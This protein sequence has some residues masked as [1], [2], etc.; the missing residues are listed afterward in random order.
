MRFDKHASLWVY[1]RGLLQSVVP[2]GFAPRQSQFL[3]KRGG[4][5]LHDLFR[6]VAGQ[7]ARRFI[8]MGNDPNVIG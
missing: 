3:I 1:D 7:K 2:P 8:N 4:A 5:P 6:V